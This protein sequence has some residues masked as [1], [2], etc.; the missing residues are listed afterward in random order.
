MNLK[1]LKALY[2]SKKC[3]TKERLSTFKTLSEVEQQK[4]FVFCLLTPQ[5]NAQRCWEAVE[6][7]F[8]YRQF[9]GEN[10]RGILKSKTRFHNNKARY[11]S[12]GLKMWNKIKPELKNANAR[13]LRNWLADN[14][15]G[16][17]LKEASHFLRNI[18]K[19]NNEIAILDR[20]ILKNMKEARKIQE[21]EIKSK[22]DY[23]Q[24]E[25]KFL[26]FANSLGIPSD[27]LD[28]LLWSKENGEVFK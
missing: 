25:Q 2:N 6:Q 13:A 28:L 7:I 22:K 14:V 17:G 21:V 11:V 15:K 9:R 16:Y 1:E 18:G 20:H 4:E 10:L 24:K 3:G 23:L 27:E 26:D 5:S 8:E 12:E 19:S